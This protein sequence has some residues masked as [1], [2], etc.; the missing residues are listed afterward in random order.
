L[1]LFPALS[2]GASAMVSKLTDIEIVRGKWDV[3]PIA[4]IVI[5]CGVIILFSP[6][7]IAEL[8]KTEYSDAISQLWSIPLIVSGLFLFLRP[9]VNIINRS[10][11]I[12][13][14]SV[15]SVLTVHGIAQPRLNTAYDL[16]PLAKL[17]RKAQIEGYIVANMDKY[18]G[19][20]NFLGRLTK[21]IVFTD[22]KLLARWL[23]DNPKSKIVS[24]HYSSPEK[25]F[26]E[27]FQ[28]FRGRY[29]AVWNGANLLKNPKIAFREN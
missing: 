3:A 20:Y 14:L 24:Y 16:K 2:L 29:I 18:H 22:S 15:I 13:A 23:R 21:P 6:A 11:S 10:I 28:T 17:L 19:Q 1:P 25:N 27:Y 7:I 9:P 8:G 5:L 4:I 26:P 12:S